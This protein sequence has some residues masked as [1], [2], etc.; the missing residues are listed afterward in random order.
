ML[1]NQVQ[2][3][4]IHWYKIISFDINWFLPNQVQLMARLRLRCD[5]WNGELQLAHSRPSGWNVFVNVFKCI[6]LNSLKCICQRFRIAAGTQQTKWVKCICQS[7]QM[8]FFKFIEMYLSKFYFFIVNLRKCICQSL[9]T[10]AGTQ[11]TK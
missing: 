10:V 6:F 2:M 1:P 3:I 4:Y 8:Y 11:Q 7:F 9:R 5:R